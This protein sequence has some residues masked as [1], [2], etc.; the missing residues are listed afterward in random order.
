MRI[1]AAAWRSPWRAPSAPCR[2]PP[3][4][5]NEIFVPVLVY[6]T[7]AYAPNGIPGP[8]ATSIT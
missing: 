7:G 2:K 5:R 8:T 4:S 1:K 6:R 3:R